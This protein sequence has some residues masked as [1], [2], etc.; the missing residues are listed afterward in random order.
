MSQPSPYIFLDEL[1]IST[2]FD[3]EV[4][5][6]GNISWTQMSSLKVEELD[7]MVTLKIEQ[8]FCDGDGSYTMVGSYEV[9]N[10]CFQFHPDGK[11]ENIYQRCEV[12]KQFCISNYNVLYPGW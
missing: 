5:K 10:I 6:F 12:F 1:I 3:R 4:D 9:G 11:L 2:K 7:M 8:I